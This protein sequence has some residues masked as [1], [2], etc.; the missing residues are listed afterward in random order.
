[1]VPLP[2]QEIIYEPHSK[3]ILLLSYYGNHTVSGYAI[4]EK[5]NKRRI[6]FG[7]QEYQLI[8]MKNNEDRLS[9]LIAEI[10]TTVK[11]P[12]ITITEPEE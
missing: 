6:T 10:N 8:R 11:E 7:K 12:L 4:D 9:V 5:G 2:I 1:M 3:L